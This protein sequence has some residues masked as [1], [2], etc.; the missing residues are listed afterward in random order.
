MT[1][2]RLNRALCS[3]F[4]FW[5]AFVTLVHFP[6]LKINRSYPSSKTCNECGYIHQTLNLSERQWTCPNG[7]ILD[8]DFNAS[9]NILKE[10]I[11]IIGAECS[12]YTGSALNKTSEKKLRVMKSEAHWSLANG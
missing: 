5:E 12:D 8:R 4:L 9:K 2:A 3:I 11:R 1:K 10:G 7:H 6:I